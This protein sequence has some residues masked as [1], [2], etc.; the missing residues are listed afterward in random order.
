MISASARRLSVFKSVVDCGGF[1]LAATQLGIAQPSVGAHIKALESQVGQPLFV[2][3]RGARPQLTKAGEAV[4]AFAVDVLH[5]SE[6]TSR[7]L[8]EIRS[9]TARE[10][11]I[12]VHR[13]IAAHFLPAR[14]T[15]FATKFPTVRVTTRIGT[16]DEVIDLI[17]SREVNLGLFLAS[18]PL[19]GMR[20]EILARE[21]LALVVS[22]HHPL[23]GSKSLSAKTLARY[24]FV[25]GMRSSRYY[26]L[27]DAALR[28]IGIAAYDVAMELGE[29]TAAKEMVRHGVSIACF[30]RCTIATELAARSLVELMPSP[31]LQDLDLRCG[32][33]GTLTE[34]ARNFL[35]CLR[36]RNAAAQ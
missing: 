9:A 20:S 8:T 1:N 24:P 34:S 4:Y 33:A 36:T 19:S 12:A 16:I 35:N 26:Q 21:P 2:R 22:P 3:N 28:K 6:A 17:C 23:V 13:D 14:L 18:G 10:I 30:P 31:R 32:Y 29:S 7:T 27:V 25:T 11:T 15:V 5:R